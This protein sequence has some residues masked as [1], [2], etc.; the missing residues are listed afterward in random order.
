[1]D[2]FPTTP[3]LSRTCPWCASA[4]VIAFGEEGLVRALARHLET[5]PGEDP[6][7]DA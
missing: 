7:D 6:V 4:R 3:H 1:V 5:C 2:G